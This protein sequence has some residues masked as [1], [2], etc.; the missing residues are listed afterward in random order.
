M[1]TTIE[2]TLRSRDKTLL[3]YATALWST[4]LAVTGLWWSINPAG[5]PLG[6][7]SDTAEMSL[8]AWIPVA[9]TAPLMI[10]VGLAGLFAALAMQRHQPSPLVRRLLTFVALGL[11]VL[12]LLVVPDLR[13]LTTMGYLCAIVGPVFV[14]GLI[15]AGMRKN[16]RNGILLGALGVAIGVAFWV[17]DVDLTIFADFGR[18]LGQG[19]ARSGPGMLAVT[20][21]FVGGGLWLTTLLRFRRRERDQCLSCG[22]PG[23][24]WMTAEAT[25]RWG[26]WVTVAAAL[27][28]LPY[29]L[30]RMT[31]FTPWPFMLDHAEL[32]ANPALRVFGLC[33]GLAAI[34]GSVLTLGLIRPWGAVF[35]RWLPLVRGAV[36]PVLP[37]TVVALMV[38]AS[39]TIAG[40]SMV[41]QLFVGDGMGLDGVEML[42]IFP[43][44]VWGPLLGAAAIAYYLRRRGSCAHCRLG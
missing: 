9:V 42:L 38:A 27:G 35:P 4:L 43:F 2:R 13:I 34:G 8:V 25:R 6:Q 41:Q 5:Y 19:L 18:G 16:P 30:T 21:A 33:L 14:L 7:D 17:F 12:F 26:T 11:A 37:P 10:G 28:P 1:T 24:A 36:V 20:A 44:P 29:G 31:W 22:R 39:V 40:R 32:V 15:G 3:E 23:A